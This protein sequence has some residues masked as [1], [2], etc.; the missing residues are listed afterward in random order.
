MAPSPEEA[1]NTARGHL[2]SHLAL[3]HARHGM[4]CFDST[5]VTVSG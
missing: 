2:W 1:A 4:R 5:G 3:D